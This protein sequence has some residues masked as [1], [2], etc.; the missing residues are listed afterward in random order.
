MKRLHTWHLVTPSPWPFFVSFAVLFLVLGFLRYFHF[1]FLGL[2]SFFIAIIF[3]F[4]FLGFWWRDV[5]RESL[6]GFHSANVKFSLRFGFVLFI[7]SEVMFFFGIFWTLFYYK[8]SPE[9]QVGAVWPPEAI[10]TLNPLDVPFLNT[11]ILIT[12]GVAITVVHHDIIRTYVAFL[13]NRGVIKEERDRWYFYIEPDDISEEDKF[14]YM[15]PFFSIVKGT[16]WL[17]GRTFCFTRHVFIRIK[18]V[19]AWRTLN[20]FKVK[21]PE[22]E[23]FSFFNRFYVFSHILFF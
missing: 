8:L 13:F 23:S 4:F 6:L 9:I 21:T 10:F 22:G 17:F 2:P 18:K 15:K 20:W 16:Q 11:L 19:G 1:F 7:A 14:E 5:I 3:L 12:S